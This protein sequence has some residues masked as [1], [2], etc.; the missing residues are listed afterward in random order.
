LQSEKSLSQHELG[1]KHQ[2]RMQRQRRGGLVDNNNNNNNNDED[3]SP[4]KQQQRCEQKAVRTSYAPAIDEEE[5]F[6]NLA[7]GVYKNI[8]VLTGAGVSTAAGIPD[9]RSPGGLFETL[10]HRYKGRFPDVNF[11]TTTPEVL[12]SRHFA[13]MYPEVYHHE[14]LPS[15]QNVFQNAHPTLTHH[16]CAHLY[17]KGWLK[18]VYTQNVDGL[19]SHP[20]L[21]IDN[22]NDNDNDNDTD[23]DHDHDHEDVVMEC[24][25]SVHKGNLVLYGDPL[26]N[27][28]A[29]MAGRDF[30]PN[31]PSEAD[32]VDLV[33]VFGTSLQVAPVCGLPNM[34]L[35]G[36][37]RVLV[38]RNLSDCMANDYFSS[39]R[40]SMECSMDV[41][42]STTCDIG[43]RKNVQL[44]PR[45]RDRKARKKWSQLL[46]EDDCDAFVERF[47]KATGT[48]FPHQE[49]RE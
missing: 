4:H 39:A 37:T 25:G 22:N 44:R 42:R 12:F 45:W 33:L 19:H 46:V 10:Q 3:G 9:F 11:S 36:C 20:S 16:L 49:C 34:A 27:E 15:M 41:T 1:I 26:P 28:F 6:Q 14:I 7:G 35:K 30:S 5:L 31:P 21:G 38:N 32:K 24:H 13:N 23:H 2:K 8:V 40:S 17:H 29:D 47:M 43:S 48:S 18:R